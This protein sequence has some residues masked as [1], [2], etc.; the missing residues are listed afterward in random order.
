[1]ALTG[2]AIL[3]L[4][5][6]YVLSREKGGRVIKIYP[7]IGRKS[8]YFIYWYDILFSLTKLLFTKF[9]ENETHNIMEIGSRCP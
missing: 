2:V 8:L 6:Y 4:E 3:M 5:K 9:G 1:M 7:L